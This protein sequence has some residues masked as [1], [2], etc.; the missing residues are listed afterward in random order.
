MN[1]TYLEGNSG[2]LNSYLSK[3][4]NKEHP[5]V[6]FFGDQYTSDVHWSNCAHPNWHGIAIIE[7]MMFQP[8]FEES[9]HLDPIDP[10]L[11]P[12]TKY[13]G[14]CYFIHSKANPKK[15]WYV[16]MVSK[17]ARY[18]VPLVRHITNFID[19]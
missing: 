8:D 19:Y 9:D 4:Y 5:Q 17:N 15:N 14:D 11:I 7:E 13:W 18:A 6:A 16:D 2:I 3:K 12:Y 10:K 1:V